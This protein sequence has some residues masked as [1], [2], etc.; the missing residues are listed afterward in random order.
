MTNRPRILYI[1]HRVPYPPNRGDRIRT[2]N[3]LKFLSQRADIDLICLADEEVTAEQRSKLEQRT[4]RLAIVPHTGIRRYIRG[5]MSLMHGDTVTEGLFYSRVLASVVK[6]WAKKTRYSSAMVS[7]SGLARYVQ[8]PILN[9]VDRVWVDL[10]DVDSQK[11]LD[12]SE[13]SK[14]PMS[15]VY[16][17][18]GRRLRQ[19]ECNL[20][21]SSE[22]LLVVSEA[23]QRLFLDFCSDA[24]VQA[25]GNGVDTDFFTPSACSPAPQTCVFVGV[26]DYLPNKDAVTWFSA[27]V[28]PKVRQKYPEATFRIVGRNPPPEV[29][30][31][32]ELDGIEMIGPVPDVR[33]WLAESACVVVPL[34]IARGI[35]NKVLEAMA[36]GRPVICSTPP[37]KGL[38]V[39]S[40]LQL[41]NADTVDEWVNQISS[42]FDDPIRADELGMAASAWVQLN[43]QWENCLVPLIDLTNERRATSEPGIEVG[44]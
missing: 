32:G 12:Y 6:Q 9:D 27:N 43:H 21:T 41:L 36:A 22:R 38:A 11:W 16:A 24:P 31:L 42:V 1:T 30:Q 28:W 37:L 15:A 44:S 5:A 29:E 13:S 2:W 25:V 17:T 3:I 40:G 4:S 20:A 39:E 19:L 14:W 33:P 8:A 26:L 34:R 10:I 7:S 18:E 23:E 35:Q